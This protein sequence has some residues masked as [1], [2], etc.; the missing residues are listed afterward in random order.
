MVLALLLSSRS[1]S[2]FCSHKHYFGPMLGSSYVLIPCQRLR[3]EVNPSYFLVLFC[4]QKHL[5]S[6]LGRNSTHNRVQ[7]RCQLCF[8]YFSP[9]PDQLTPCFGRRVGKFYFEEASVMSFLKSPSLFLQFLLAQY[10]PIY[11]TPPA[12]KNR[13]W[14]Q[15]PR[16][17]QMW[18][19]VWYISVW[20]VPPNFI[21]PS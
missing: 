2:A 15:L 18:R 8:F 5:K 9:G 20:E 6:Q 10:Q 4:H 16:F 11:A 19:Q 7:S 14:H 21:L 17:H 3:T 13:Q 12:T 1:A